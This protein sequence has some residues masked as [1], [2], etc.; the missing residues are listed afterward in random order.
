MVVSSHRFSRING[1]RPRS[2]SRDDG[3]RWVRSQPNGA[4]VS[5]ASA[6]IAQ[7]WRSYTRLSKGDFLTPNRTPH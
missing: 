4:I 7:V 5:V 6:A 1:Q 2:R 3:K